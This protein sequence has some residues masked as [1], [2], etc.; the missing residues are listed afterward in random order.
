MSFIVDADGNVQ[1]ARA[2]SSTQPGFET[3]AVQAV[4]KWKFTPGQV[5]GLAVNTR[6]QVPIA[7]TVSNEKRP[8][9]F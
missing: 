7:F 1:D 9:W 3:S 5:K 6:M 2:I 8:N 4:A